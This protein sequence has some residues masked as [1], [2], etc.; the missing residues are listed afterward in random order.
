MATRVGG[1]FEPSARL[2]PAN[3]LT[4]LRL[5]ATLPLV[6]AVLDLGAAWATFL[7][8]V[9]VSSTDF[10]DGWVARR[11]GVT[12]SGA[13]LD[14]L[15]D[16]VVVLGVLGAL[17]ATGLAPWAPVLVIAARE[18][19]ISAYR[20]VVARRGRSVPARPLAKLKTATQD[21]AVCLMLLP[22]T[23]SRD[24]WAGRDLLWVSVVLAI[25]SAAQYLL[26]SHRPAAALSPPVPAAGSAVGGARRVDDLPG[27]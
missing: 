3:G 16:K 25:W 22:V 2:T 14:P 15:A 7:A 13:F 8:W 11:Q 5:L 24:A 26:D 20:S 6:I 21:G 10:L 23:A 4:A 12:R 27:S 18:A 17:A 9:L 1:R 19:A